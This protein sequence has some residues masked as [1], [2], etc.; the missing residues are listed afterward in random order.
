MDTKQSNLKKQQR[1]EFVKVFGTK[2]LVGPQDDRP[3]CQALQ[4]YH[5][6]SSMLSTPKYAMSHHEFQVP[7]HLFYRIFHDLSCFIMLHHASS[8]ANIMKYHEISSF[9]LVQSA[10]FQ[11]FPGSPG[12]P[13]RGSQGLA[14]HWQFHFLHTHRILWRIQGQCRSGGRWDLGGHLG[15]L[16]ESS[17]ASWLHGFSRVFL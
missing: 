14:V 16:D 5:Q 6:A 4:P 7:N 10:S 15:G 9:N 11:D 8:S 12:G 2:T 3:M 1:G 17:W 13:A